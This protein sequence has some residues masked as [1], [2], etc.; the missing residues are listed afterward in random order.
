MMTNGK[1]LGADAIV[2]TRYQVLSLS[3]HRDALS[4]VDPLA[5]YTFS[6][7]LH[8]YLILTL[9]PC[10]SPPISLFI[11]L[12]LCVAVERDL[13]YAQVSATES[14]LTGV[15]VL[16]LAYGTAVKLD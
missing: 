13:G 9:S 10:L 3:L 2:A 14:K 1:T 4:L 6:H 11:I 7:S 8:T 12:S 16:V 15:S 5:L